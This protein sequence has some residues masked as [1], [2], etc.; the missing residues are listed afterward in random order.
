[1]SDWRKNILVCVALPNYY[2]LTTHETANGFQIVESKD[3]P[4]LTPI[5]W[6]PLLILY[7]EPTARFLLGKPLRPLERGTRAHLRN[8][9]KNERPRGV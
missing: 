5:V 8:G 3:I 7:R 6:S 9:G 4:D 2:Y 1:M